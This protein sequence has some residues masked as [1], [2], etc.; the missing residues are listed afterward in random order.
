MSNNSIWNN[1]G[2]VSVS[3]VI[4]DHSSVV[5][6]EARVPAP[7][8]SSRAEPPPTGPEVYSGGAKLRFVQRLSASYLELADLLEIPSHD[9][10]SGAAG[11]RF[12]WEWL[13]VRER[14]GDLRAA[15][16]ETKRMDLVRMLDE[17]Q[18][19]HHR[20]LAGT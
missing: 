9:L 13:E 16:A 17:D 12:I 20:G 1:G 7:A 15:L 8:S 3:G 2:N 14:L 5:R 18:R 19:N 4:G 11:A 6:G 10:P